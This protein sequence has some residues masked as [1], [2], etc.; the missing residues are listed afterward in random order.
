MAILDQLHDEIDQ[1]EDLRNRVKLIVERVVRDEI[2]AAVEASRGMGEDVLTTTLIL[3]ARRVEHEI[4]PI[5][6]EAFKT[7]VQ[8][9]EKRRKA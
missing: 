5:T 2:F 7:G 1:L 6:T 8:F 9:A 4:T 3:L